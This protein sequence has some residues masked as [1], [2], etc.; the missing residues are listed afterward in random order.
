MMQ[1]RL[2]RAQWNSHYPRYEA[3]PTRDVF[4]SLMRLF[5]MCGEYD[6]GH[7]CR[8]ML[9]TT[10]DVWAIDNRLKDPY[11]PHHPPMY[12]PPTKMGSQPQPTFYERVMDSVVWAD[13]DMVNTIDRNRVQDSDFRRIIALLVQ[14]LENFY[15]PTGYDSLLDIRM[16]VHD[17]LRNDMVVYIH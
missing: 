16:D 17:W 11:M 7:L 4:L 5:P 14:R 2:P 3:I 10:F 12:E 6:V 8:H 1:Y 9:A 13:I 15:P